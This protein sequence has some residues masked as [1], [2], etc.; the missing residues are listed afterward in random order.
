MSG[1]PV[2]QCGVPV[3]RKGCL[4]LCVARPTR[5]TARDVFRSSTLIQGGKPMIVNCRSIHTAAF[6]AAAV[7][8]LPAAA[9]RASSVPTPRAQGWLVKS[10]DQIQASIPAKDL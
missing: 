1:V 6:A 7:L 5:T 4:F 9:A 3:I 8:L 10:Y 2:N